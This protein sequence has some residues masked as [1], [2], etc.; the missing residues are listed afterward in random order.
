MSGLGKWF[1]VSCDGHMSPAQM[2][3]ELPRDKVCPIM[4]FEE[5]GTTVV[6]IF[7]SKQL[8]EKFAKRNTPRTWTIGT[9][10][11]FSDNIEQ[12]EGRGYRVVEFSW[13]KKKTATVV[14]LYLDNQ[15]VE[16]DNTGFR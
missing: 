15:T 16:T 4:C 13:P 11:V 7:T 9:M 5:D 1:A 12:L 3:A 14:P 10:E 2:L 8:A 6:P